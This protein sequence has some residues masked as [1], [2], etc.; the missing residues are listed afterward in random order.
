MNQEMDKSPERNKKKYQLGA[1]LLIWRLP[2][3]RVVKEIAQWMRADLHF[4]TTVVMALLE[5]GEALLVSL[6]E[7]TNL[8]AFHV[9]CVT[10][11][12]K[13]TQLARQIRGDM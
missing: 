4:Q 12:P 11:M 13:D 5:A 8:C 10:I 3:E 6:L 2:F 1:E 7:Q 9:K